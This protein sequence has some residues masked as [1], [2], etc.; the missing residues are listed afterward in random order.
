MIGRRAEA[1]GVRWYLSD[2]LGT[3]R[4]LADAAGEVIDHIAYDAF[5]NVLAESNPAAG[6]RFRFTGR[7]F[8]AATGQYYYRARY[9]DGR[10]GR[11]TSEDP[12][13]LAA[14]DVNVYRYVL[15][16]PAVLA[17]P[18]GLE[19][20]PFPPTM[21]DPHGPG[22]S[23]GSPLPPPP[24]GY[25]YGSAIVT[26]PEAGW[27]YYVWSTLS[28]PPPKWAML[29]EYALLDEQN[30]IVK[31]RPVPLPP[32]LTGGQG[33][34]GII[35]PGQVVGVNGAGPCVGVILIPP[36]GDM[37]AYAFHFQNTTDVDDGFEAVGAGLNPGGYTAIVC[38]NEFA[39]S[40]PSLLTLAE[41]M[42][43]LEDNGY[44]VK[45]YVPGP[46]VY[47]DSE[48]NIYWGPPPGSTTD[49]Y[50][51]NLRPPPPLPPMFP[52][53]PQGF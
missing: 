17:D 19:A 41:V 22:G 23:G 27:M 37:P 31:S 20:P 10:I 18:L 25:I 1:E 43:W 9:Y 45:G 48:G 16:R 49:N 11:F 14:G 28:M 47:I 4:D 39:Y 26:L 12:L 52:E 6:D 2:H 5:G 24:P 44:P 21:G 42:E 32:G 33:W 40:K 30:P 13:G 8:D 34:C 7:E 38:G 29:G 3:V 36:C 51:Q 46:S 53:V 15:N 50:L 35:P